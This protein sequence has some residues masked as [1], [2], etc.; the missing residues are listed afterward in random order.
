MTIPEIINSHSGKG[1]SIE[2][3]PPLK[4]RGINRLFAQIEQILPF[5]PS[6]INITTHRSELVFKS[7]PDGLYQRVS[8]RSRPG[9]VAV[10]AAIQQRYNIPAVPHIICSG[11]SK[12][13]TE[14]ALIDLNFLGIDNLLVLR[15]DK[16]K[17]D[18]RF[19][20]SAGGHAYAYQLQMQINDF[21]KGIFTDGTTMDDSGSASF[22]YGVAGYPEK[23]DEAPNIDMDIMWLKH[24]VDNGASYIVTQMFFD[25]NK[26]YDFVDRCRAAG[27]NVPIIPGIKPV[28]NRSQLTILPKVFHVDL[29]TP[30]ADRL[31][32]CANDDEAKQI[33]VD[34]TIKQM[35]DLYANGVKSIHIYSLNAVPSVV[36]ILKNV[37]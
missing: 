2:V 20:P 12:I 31:M 8:E 30:L 32:Q 35:N 28:V 6:Y 5:A 3:L 18:A 23:H 11:Y 16:A 1:F 37:L 29:P 10:A 22:D 26:Y 13:E 17:H 7:T 25:N 9:T 19:T 21:N 24:K 34:W 27:I 4:G 15:G 36:K 14:Y 33:G